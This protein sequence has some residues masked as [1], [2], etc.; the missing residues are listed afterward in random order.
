MKKI[1]KSTRIYVRVSTEEKALLQS[2][3]GELSISEFIRTKLFTHQ[4]QVKN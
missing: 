1:T 2:K 4:V 3:K